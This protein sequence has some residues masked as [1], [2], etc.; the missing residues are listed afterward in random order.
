MSHDPKPLANHEIVTLA[1]YRLGGALQAVDTEDV[2]VESSK[3]LPGRFSWRKHPSQISL[4]SVRKRLWDAQSKAKGFCYLRGSEREGW[5]LTEAGQ[6]FAAANIDRV[7]AGA[8][9]ATPR[10]NVNERNWIRQERKRM[11]ESTA[12]QKII[13]G[14]KDDITYLEAA[15]FFRIDEYVLG[16]ARDRKILRLVHAFGADSVLG[17]SVHILGNRVREGK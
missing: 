13:A 10:S 1:V 14:R 6:H 2:A 12:H 7:S 3:I 5:M 16:V 9:E 4:D 8:S 15:A 17:N 11:I